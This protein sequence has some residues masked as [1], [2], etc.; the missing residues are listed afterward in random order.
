MVPPPVGAQSEASGHA[1][2]NQATTTGTVDVILFFENETAR[3]QFSTDENLTVTGGD[4]IQLLPVLFATTTAATIPAL[5]AQPG[6]K[7][8]RVDQ[9]VRRPLPSSN[10]IQTTTRAAE[11]EASTTETTQVVPW[12]VQRIEARTAADRV[13]YSARQ[14]VTIAVVDSGIDYDHPDLDDSVVWGANFTHGSEQYGRETANDQNG[15][16]TAVAGIISASDND[17]GVVGVAPGTPLYAIK[18]LGDDNTGTLSSFLQGLDAAAKGP[19]GTLGTT[20]DADI[21]QTSVGTVSSHEQLEAAV[22]A[23]ADH[24]LIVSSAG[25]SG[26]ATDSVTYPAKYPAT[27]AVAATDKTDATTI[28]SSE[29]EAVDVAAPGENIQTLRRGGGTTTFAGTSA[30]APHASGT[31]ALLLAKDLEDGTREFT[32]QALYDRLQQT[33]LDIDADGVDTTSGYG[34]I[35]ANTT[36]PNETQLALTVNRTTIPI[37][38]KAALSV[39]DAKT[40]DPINA[41]LA[42]DGRTIPTGPDGTAIYQFTKTKNYSITATRPDTPQE[43]YNSTSTAVHVIA[44]NVTLAPKKKSVQVGDTIQFNISAD[45]YIDSIQS[46]ELEI[47]IG[48]ISTAVFT[49]FTASGIV[50]NEAQLTVEYAS[51]NGSVTVDAQN[52]NQ[53]ASI[54]ATTTVET[55]DSGTTTLSLYNSTIT[56]ATYTYTIDTGDTSAVTVIDKSGPTV[57]NNASAQDLDN[58]GVYE[59]VNG[60]GEFTIVDVNAFFQNYKKTPIQENTDQFDFNSDGQVTIVDVNRLFQLS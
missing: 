24:A 40:G 47:Q 57:I 42:I 60:D 9:Q 22:T 19:D 25:N 48:N 49:D 17:R 52:V 8:V 21:I 55:V 43:V 45:S 29:G 12:G 13:T 34:R 14:N 58:N 38:G 1:S 3:E 15:H 4:N 32:N 37:G 7:T 26:P 2:E 51:N 5:R 54:L 41:T 35:R 33:A 11:I 53:S 59:D 36:L 44:P 28:Y 50:D 6:I 46:Y 56:D 30:A 23:A 31:L 16:G 10:S 39:T 20:D 27:I 18:V